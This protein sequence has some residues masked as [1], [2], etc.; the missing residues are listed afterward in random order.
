MSHDLL[1]LH[2]QCKPSN[3]NFNFIPTT[4]L[5]QCPTSRRLSSALNSFSSGKPRSSYHRAEKK[6]WNSTLCHYCHRIALRNAICCSCSWFVFFTAWLTDG[7]TDWQLSFQYLLAA[8]SN[9]YLRPSIDDGR[10]DF[11]ASRKCTTDKSHLFFV[12]V[13]YV[14]SGTRRHLRRHPQLYLATPHLLRC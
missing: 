12:C 8:R 11:L 14:A 9:W 1:F 3:I 5:H 13:Y 2:A 10:T 4:K 6:R 7:L